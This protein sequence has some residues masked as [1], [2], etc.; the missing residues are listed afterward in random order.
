M[1]AVSV[2]SIR[3][4]DLLPGDEGSP[5]RANIRVAALADRPSYETLSYVWGSQADL[6]AI[7]VSGRRFQVTRNLHAALQRLRRRKQARTLW[8]DQLCIDQENLAEKA[9]QIRLMRAIYT[10]CTQGLIWLGEIAEDIPPEAAADAFAYLKWYAAAG[11]AFDPGVLPTP[12]CMGSMTRFRRAMRAM[13][14]VGPTG[15][16]WWS[17]IW[18][19]Q[20]AVLPHAA[21]VHWGPLS[22][23][24]EAL[25]RADA[26]RRGVYAADMHISEAMSDVALEDCGGLGLM[27][28]RVQWLNISRDQSD[29][30]MQ[31]MLRWRQREATQLHDCVYGLL[32]LSPA[33]TFP[34]CEAY[35]YS[36]PVGRL[37]TLMTLDIIEHE[38]LVPLS[39]DPRMED[40]TGAPDIPRW[41]YDPS[42]EPKYR[43]NG[44]HQLWGYQFYEANRGLPESR[45]V[46]RTEKTLDLMGTCVGVVQSVGEA[47]YPQSETRESPD[48]VLQGLVQEWWGLYESSTASSRSP[49][50]TYLGG[51]TPREAFG[52]LMLGDYL[53]DGDS[54]PDTEADDDDINGVYSFMDHGNFNWTYET[55]WAMTR[56][57]RFFVTTAG[58]IGLGHCETSPG[59]EIWVFNLGRVPF[60]LRRRR[61]RRVGT[62]DEAEEEEQEKEE[63]ALPCY[64]FMG[65]CHVEGIMFGELFA[66]DGEDKPVQQEV[67]I[68]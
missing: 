18:T 60:S 42:G 39:I 33:G 50:E 10:Q 56:H 26:T 21:R 64:D 8:I 63:E 35:D 38:G 57:Q 41:A 17:R 47:Y 9:A 3:V 53:R 44:W 6:V 13:K 20:E 54:Y 49:E 25:S 1:D 29:T 34:S 15:A 30:R 23:T 66:E 67:R 28:V 24:W 31:I 61:R 59:D 19:V 22:I 12:P 5:I 45:A 52:R 27:L 46:Q 62:R 55:L 4:L 32:G 11:D 16:A 43:T 2:D 14:R 37:Y 65:R 7:E 51:L 40:G 48:S 58:L 68:F 36:M